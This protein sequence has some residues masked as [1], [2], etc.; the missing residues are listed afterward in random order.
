MLIITASEKVAGVVH[1]NR[2]ALVAT[3]GITDA[4]T[5]PKQALN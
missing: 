1:M 2:E 5:R 3:K 4:R